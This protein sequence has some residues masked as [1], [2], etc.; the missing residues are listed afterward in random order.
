[1]CSPP[2][3]VTES[4]WG[5]FEASIRIYFRDPAEQ[6][7]DLFHLIKL[8]PPGLQQNNHWLKKVRVFFCF[9][10]CSGRFSIKIH[11]SVAFDSV[12][13]VFSTLDPP[14]SASRAI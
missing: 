13:F 7:I 1:V 9:V 6:P 11:G 14:T 3:E 4:G 5:E 8:Y 12:L 10:F 2:F